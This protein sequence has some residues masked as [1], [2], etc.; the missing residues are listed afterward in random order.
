MFFSSH[1]DGTKELKCG[2]GPQMISYR[3]TE[4][5]SQYFENLM[6]RHNL[7]PKSKLTEDG[8]NAGTLSEAVHLGKWREQGFGGNKAIGYKKLRYGTQDYRTFE[9][10]TYR[11][12]VAQ[13]VGQR[14]H[15]PDRA[16]SP[17]ELGLDIR[18]WDQN[19]EH[20]RIVISSCE[21]NEKNLKFLSTPLRYT[22]ILVDPQRTAATPDPTKS[23]ALVPQ[24]DDL[25]VLTTEMPSWS[26]ERLLELA[27]GGALALTTMSMCLHYLPLRRVGFIKV[28]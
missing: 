9:K 2:V 11:Q 6:P 28:P 15:R 21:T 8:F 18:R 19:T 12:K 23:Y 3:R 24:L 17:I 7:R 16:L 25:E 5:N 10:T 27:T 14:L 20:T 1:Q 22:T 4:R 13:H 26:L